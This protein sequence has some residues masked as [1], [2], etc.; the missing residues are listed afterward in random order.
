MPDPTPAEMIAQIAAFPRALLLVEKRG[1][2]DSNYLARIIEEHEG[3]IRATYIGVVQ[4]DFPEVVAALGVTEYPTLILFED[5]K[6]R[7][8]ATLDTLIS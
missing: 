8:R 6:E 1:H 3:E 5:G 7:R 2:S 4:Q